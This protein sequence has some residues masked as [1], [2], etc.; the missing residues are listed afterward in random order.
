MNQWWEVMDSDW[1]SVH[2]HHICTSVTYTHTPQT[3][4]RIV[5][6]HACCLGDENQSDSSPAE[7]GTSPSFPLQTPLF[8]IAGVRE[9]DREMSFFSSW[10]ASRPSRLLSLTDAEISSTCRKL[11]IT[12]LT[13][14]ARAYWFFSLMLLAKRIHLHN[15]KR[16]T[17]IE[18]H[19]HFG[20]DCVIRSDWPF[21]TMT[22]SI[23]GSYGN[24]PPVTQR[25]HI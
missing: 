20:C 13:V 24:I 19:K 8:P 15:V 2:V 6:L 18:T 21:A 5:G 11:S 17:D 9:W 3:K 10:F 25:G 1:M 22:L 12:S 23:G 16:Q 7:G 4:Q 14:H